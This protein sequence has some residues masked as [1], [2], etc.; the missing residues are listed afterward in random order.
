MKSYSDLLFHHFCLYCNDIMT[1]VVISNAQMTDA[2][3]VC[4]AVD[5]LELVMTRTDFLL[6]FFNRL[7]QSVPL[8]DMQSVVQVK[9]KIAVWWKTL[10]TGLFCFALISSAWTTLN[11]C[12][13]SGIKSWSCLL[14]DCECGTTG[15]DF[16]SFVSLKRWLWHRQCRIKILGK[17]VVLDRKPRAKKQWLRGL[18][19]TKQ[20][21]ICKYCIPNITYIL[22][23]L[24][25]KQYF[26]K[27][28]FLNITA[29]IKQLV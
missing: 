26:F 5:L 19:L 29:S 20:N 10:Q 11:I 15:Y 28:Y 18:L 1:S 7:N 23:I 27:S 24:H 4:P 12:G 17:G 21:P 8:S 3:Q 2:L 16:L 9:M 14:H 13:S 22:F 6:Q 25:N